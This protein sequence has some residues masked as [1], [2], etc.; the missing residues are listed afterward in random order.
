MSPADREPDSLTAP[1]V[2]SRASVL[3]LGGDPADA[4]SV[5]D[6]LS[7]ERF[8]LFPATSPTEAQSLLASR[9]IDLVLVDIVDPD[10]S[11]WDLIQNIRAHDSTRRIPVILLT[12]SGAAADRRQSVL[13]GV[14]RFHAPRLRSRIA[15]DRLRNRRERCRHR[16]EPSR[17]ERVLLLRSQAAVLFARCDRPPS[18]AGSTRSAAHDSRRSAAAR[19]RDSGSTRRY[20][21]T[22]YQECP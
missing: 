19:R 4:S 17:S 1:A 3:L 2:R 13:L 20:G 18:R 9:P 6:S 14:I 10:A 8:Q 5:R 12:S 22:T 15:G 7:R 11:G 16:D 21:V